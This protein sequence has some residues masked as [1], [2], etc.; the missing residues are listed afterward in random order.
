[1]YHIW[2]FDGVSDEEDRQIV[3]YQIVVS[4]FGVELDGKTSWIASRI[5]RSSCTHHRRETDEDICLFL[6]VLE[7]FRASV[8]CHALVHLEVAV[9]AGTFSVNHTLRNALTVEVRELLD[10]KHILQQNR[11]TFADGE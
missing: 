3:A 5:G 7:E 9:R 10:K 1:M 8:F 2:E 11:S 6:R 4:V